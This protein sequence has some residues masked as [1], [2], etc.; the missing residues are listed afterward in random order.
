MKKICLSLMA[1]LA[2]GSLMAG[3]TPHFDL[4]VG[5]D[6][7]LAHVRN[8]YYGNSFYS[9]F[10]QMD[11]FHFGG[12]L[13]LDFTEGQDKPGL[14]IG[15]N[16]Q[17]LANNLINHNADIKAAAQEIKSQAKA[18]GASR[19]QASDYVFMHTI[20]IPIRF[21]YTHQ[22]TNDWRFFA[23]TGPQIR[24]HVSLTDTKNLW[25]EAD[26]KRTGSY[27]NK[28]Y[29]SGKKTEITWLNGIEQKND[30]QIDQIELLD[31]FDMSWGFGIGFGW[32][33]LSLQFTYDLGMV[34]LYN[35]IATKEAKILGQYYRFNSDAL[36]VTLGFR[37]K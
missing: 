29:V 26:G 20:Q 9:D 15:V 31:C 34:N 7:G 4:E 14:L 36:A 23:L 5:Y 27:L 32:K 33:A 30:Q 16:Y 21:Q 11:G 22:F 8:N 13:L 28:D 19:V 1:V 10:A 24:L 3:V 35:N 12:D 17:F 25:Y 6:H 18:A 2:A 37:L